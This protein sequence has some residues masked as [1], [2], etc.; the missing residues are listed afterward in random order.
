MWRIFLVLGIVALFFFLNN[1]FPYILQDRDTRYRTLYF[2]ALLMAMVA[3]F[4][5]SRWRLAPS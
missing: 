1:E 5:P 3:T 2:L 4:R